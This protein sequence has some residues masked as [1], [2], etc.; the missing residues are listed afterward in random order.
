MHNNIIISKKKKPTIGEIVLLYGHRFRDSLSGLFLHLYKSTCIHTCK[1]DCWLK[2]EKKNTKSSWLKWC[3]F[4][5]AYISTYETTW[6]YENLDQLS[7][8][9]WDHLGKSAL[10]TLQLSYK[11]VFLR[12]C[13]VHNI[14]FIIYIFIFY[15]LQWLK[16]SRINYNVQ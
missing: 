12:C 11:Y 16:I 13:S 4:T 9:G 2:K 14:N 15:C 6:N 3:H 5:N 1:T 8:S 7:Q 10:F